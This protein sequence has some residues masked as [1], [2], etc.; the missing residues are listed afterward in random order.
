MNL[1]L[2]DFAAAHPWLAA[3]CIW[4]TMILLVAIAWLIAAC[5]ENAIN[6]ILR[7]GNLACNTFIILV[8]GYAPQSV[9]AH[10]EETDDKPDAP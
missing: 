6:L 3:W 7:L 4:P 5:A 2:F 10:P 8:R 9:E 1:P